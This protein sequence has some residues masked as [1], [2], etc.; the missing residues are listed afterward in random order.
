MKL[1]LLAQVRFLRRAPWSAFTAVLGVSI[2]VASI[3]AVHLIGTTV[4]RT[5]DAVRPPHLAGLTHLLEHSDHSAV[6]YFE[7]RENWRR[8]AWP[9]VRALVPV[10]EGQL[11][12]N[13]RR[14]RVIGVD[15]LAYPPSA[16]AGL[17]ERTSGRS[18]ATRDA[19]GSNAW[20]WRLLDGSAAVVDES[21]G[22]KIG[23]TVRIGARSFS[24]LDVIDGGLGPA[25]HLDIAAA[26]RVLERTADS[27]DYV[28]LVARDPW[29]RWRS[30]LDALMPG[31]AA[32][33]PLPAAPVEVTATGFVARAIASELP[34]NEFARS[35]LFNVGALGLLALVVAGF[36]VHQIALIWV[37]RQRPVL[38]RLHA[39]G[40][41]PAERAT[42]FVA[43]FAML[44][45]L[46]TLVG[47]IA[48]IELA[49]WLLR[50]ST[51]AQIAGD[52]AVWHRADTPVML[53]KAF[54]AGAGICGLG[55][56]LAARDDRPR[57]NA[58]RWRALV[59]IASVLLLAVGVA[60][61]SSGIAGGFAA[62]LALTVLA[63][64]FVGPL[65]GWLRRMLGAKP[66]GDAG[67][68]GGLTRLLVRLALREAVWRP[69]VVGVAIAALGLAVATSLGVAT[70]VD[71]LRS[72]FARML[73]QR[74]AD[75]LYLAGEPPE[76]EAARQWLLARPAT[77]QVSRQGE[78][79]VRVGHTMPQQRETPF[80]RAADGSTASTLLALLGYTTF[81]A[82]ET[83]RY[84]YSGALA[85]DQILVNERLARLLG[86]AAG[87][88]LAVA[89]VPYRVVHVFPGFGDVEPRLL[90]DVAGLP[91]AIGEPVFDRL[92]VRH[93]PDRSL[94]AELSARF[95]ELAVTER[96]RVREQ[97]FA[98]F[99]R[100]FAVTRALTLLALVV[101]AV[102][103]YTA[104]TALRL[105]QAP[106]RRLLEAEGAVRHELALVTL[107][108][109][110]TIGMLAVAI[111]L[112]LGI[113]MAWILCRVINPRAFGWTIELTL[114]P[115][116][117]LP[118]LLLGLAATLL[119]GVLPAPREQGTLE[120]NV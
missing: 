110:G 26:A 32:G 60:M 45:L 82:H 33:L 72:G 25:I 8:E 9:A 28:G 120:E 83:A 97:S 58:C 113:A 106:T 21:L 95:P 3:V 80:A 65:L 88:T 87:S 108:R 84:G 63:T 77:L 105:A 14:T 47:T 30:A 100:T 36:L 78:I 73:E 29:E 102:G 55:G 10:I 19:R 15:W 68:R 90:A 117:W 74:L 52:V 119:A 103:M 6:R 18:E 101:A 89:G 57:G 96:E 49:D 93:A 92:S 86:V 48:G 76:V 112:P 64:L 22:L 104:L 81:H 61:P 20:G 38:E 23:D 44:G 114:A 115:A 27:L 98:I 40:A 67:A 35:I 118:A 4:M 94:V 1:L 42:A 109:A 46:A 50:I 69:E 75:D 5:L 54:I 39:L 91:A 2:A 41:T 56:W 31:F 7:L 17:T 13:G 79:R 66:Y 71:S 85:E 107:V 51:S 70:M 53:G 37:A 16:G 11:T 116:A 99:D 34:A 62:L 59:V 24:V 12:L 111:A 43:V